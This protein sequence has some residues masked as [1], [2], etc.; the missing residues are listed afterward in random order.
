MAN[1]GFDEFTDLCYHIGLALMTWQ[2]VEE[3][4]FK[5]FFKLIGAPNPE[6]ASLAYH[7]TESF[8]QRRVMVSRMVDWMLKATDQ[9][10]KLAPIWQDT[11]GGLNKALKDASENRNKLA[12]YTWQYDIK[13]IKP[14]EY[15]T[16][17]TRL[18]PSSWNV[19]SQILGRVASSPKHNLDK[20]VVRTYIDEFR[21]L[22]KA[23][24]EFH[25]QL[26]PWPTE[27][28][29]LRSIG[30][31]P[32]YLTESHRSPSS[33]TPPNNPPSGQKDRQ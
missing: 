4:H 9:T 5:L 11:S 2:D 19:V 8:D 13:E 23:L 31:P 24:D 17:S 18:Q 30:L 26:V 6:I 29:I 33:T 20:T 25:R 28:S 3:A 14:G 16:G 7:A 21:R 10:A 27:P 1:P 22:T 32:S 12:H 15:V